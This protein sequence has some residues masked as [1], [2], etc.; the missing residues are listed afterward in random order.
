[1]SMDRWVRVVAVLMALW[2]ISPAAEVSATGED[3]NTGFHKAV[4]EIISVDVEHSLL[5]I[6]DIRP[7]LLFGAQNRTFQIT[8]ETTISDG[9][10][11]LTLEALQPGD[12]I[13]IAYEKGAV[14]PRALSITV[15][16]APSV[17]AATPSQ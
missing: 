17:A 12:E 7:G 3:P 14:P 2:S 1:M 16:V 15:T 11:D 4:G 6:S 8:T 9:A 5:A 13:V 10:S